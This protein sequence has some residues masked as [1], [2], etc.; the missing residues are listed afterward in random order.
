MLYSRTLVLAASLTARSPHTVLMHGSQPDAAL[1]AATQRWVDG[2]IVG[3]NL[4]PFA[5]AVRPHTRYVVCRARTMATFDAELRRLD[6]VDPA[7]AAT[8]LVLLPGEEFAEFAGLM[9]LQPDVQQLA[10]EMGA[11]VQILP[12][13]PLA[14]YGAAG[15]DDDG[16]EEE[17]EEV[18]VEVEVEVEEEE[19]QAAQLDAFDFSTRSPVPMLHLLRQADVD[20][21]E[22]QWFSQGGL[23]IQERNAAYLRG[24]GYEQ[25]AALRAAALAESPPST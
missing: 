15:E 21:G 1:V 9:I 14:T 5:A 2:I 11:D 13:H 22:E 3:H 24:I 19:A 12:F 10:D 7:K 25:A 4:C 8:T 16:D 23:P 17:E 6:A 18:E 20:A